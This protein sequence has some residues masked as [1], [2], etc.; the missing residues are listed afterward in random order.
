MDATERTQKILEAE[1][2]ALSPW[3]PFR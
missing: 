3:W 2:Q 1:R